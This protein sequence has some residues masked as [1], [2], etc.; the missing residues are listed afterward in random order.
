[1]LTLYVGHDRKL[2]VAPGDRLLIGRDARAG[3]QVRGALPAHAVVERF[4]EGIWVRAATKGASLRVNGA[5]A[6]EQRVTS[7][8]RVEVV[9][10]ALQIV[11]G[12]EPRDAVEAELLELIAAG[13]EAARSVYADLLDEQG[14]AA[15]ASWLRLEHRLRSAPDDELYALM[16]QLTELSKSVGLGFRSLV[17][18][19][20]VEG[21]EA[22]LALKCPRQWDALGPSRA[23]GVRFCDVCSK[24][25]YYCDDVA[26]A[27]RH[28]WSGD[29]VALDLT[30]PR[31][32]GD[33]D[34]REHVTMGVP[35]LEE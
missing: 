12:W 17:G 31:I 9:G 32:E 10:T 20:V 1:M 4:P 27:Q 26:T 7:F 28:A 8:D 34:L 3:L 6:V 30:A 25:V 13:D 11:D 18:R 19:P 22:K 15:E 2:F 29:C 24:N 33:L 23:P 5:D 16:V 35:A 14:C 21:C